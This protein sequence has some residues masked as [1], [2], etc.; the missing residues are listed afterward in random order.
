MSLIRYRRDSQLTKERFSAITYFDMSM[1]NA[2]LLIIP[3]AI[4]KLYFCFDFCFFYNL[5]NSV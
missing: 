3:A 4:K 5:A 1:T 2:K